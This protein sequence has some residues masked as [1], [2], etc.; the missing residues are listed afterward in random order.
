MLSGRA[1]RSVDQAIRAAAEATTFGELAGSAVPALV[2]ALD[3]S[4]CLF[5]RVDAGG[6]LPLSGGLVHVFGD[7]AKGYAALDPWWEA[8][9]RFNDPVML[10][11]RYLDYAA[12]RRSGAYGYYRQFD[13]EHL[14]SIRLT[15]A[16]HAKDGSVEVFFVRGG[17]QPDFTGR[18]VRALGRALPAL[19]AATRRCLR[20]GEAVCARPVLEWLTERGDPRA[21]LALDAGGR[22][23]WA[24]ARAERLLERDLGGRRALPE[25][26]VAA[27][28]RLAALALRRAGGSADAP[29]F[30]V[31]F[32]TAAG[33]RVR[34]DLSVARTR[35]GDPF[36]L[37]ELEDLSAAGGR[38]TGWGGLT[39]A[40]AAVLDL[41]ALGLT[42]AEIARRL[43]ISAETVRT[44][45]HRIFRKL[46]V[47][48]RTQA[49]LKLHERF[50]P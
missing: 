11:A 26:L 4:D 20:A 6:P 16:P 14:L 5:Y 21:R 50:A 46:G 3:A 35:A 24:S 7:Y 32:E 13:L 37:A 12:W 34:A 2:R 41:L 8:K 10:G 17:C 47:T 25:P 27:A 1:E 29:P 28:R 45:L 22:P 23:I 30:A 44:H 42:N 33:K 31:A 19:E 48:T 9:S 36:V 39:P 49:A 40:E 43:F 38:A 18:H 15:R